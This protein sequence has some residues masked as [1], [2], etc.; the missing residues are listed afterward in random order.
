MSAGDS[1][2]VPA[3][4]LPGSI[5][6]VHRYELPL[7]RSHVWSLISDVEQ[8]R[9]WWPW[10]RSFDAG[11]LAQGEEWHCMV[12]PPVPYLVRFTV[13]IEE[14]EAGALVR[15]S[16]GGDVVGEA[17]LTLHDADDGCVTTLQSTLAPGNRALGL[18]SRFAGP[19]ARFGHD[20]VLDSGARQ[21]IARAVEPLA[22]D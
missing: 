20:W 6:T 11:A 17:T 7:A 3:S 2:S 15:A 16:V 5:S 19:V 21:F 13:F 12:Q 9:T 8:Y 10:L 14:V 18:V 1:G 4:D 22:G